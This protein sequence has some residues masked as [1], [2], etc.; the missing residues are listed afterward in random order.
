V[1][2]VS[3]FFLPAHSPFHS[4]SRIFTLR[5]KTSRHSLGSSIVS[6]GVHLLFLLPSLILYFTSSTGPRE[7]VNSVSWEEI[8][9][10]NSEIKG[11]NQGFDLELEIHIETPA[12]ILSWKIPSTIP[13]LHSKLTFSEFR[14]AHAVSLFNVVLTGREA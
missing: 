5:I 9:Y 4:I 8:L 13:K 10:D 11:C 3:F 1:R 6:T 7:V 14:V 12:T 2:P